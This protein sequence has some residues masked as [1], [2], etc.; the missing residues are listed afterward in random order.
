MAS[1]SEK[2]ALGKRI[3][4]ALYERGLIRT[5]YRDKPEGWTLV[6]GAWSPFYIQLRPVCSHPELLRDVSDALGRMIRDEAPHV[7]KIVGVAMAGI[8]LAVAASLSCRL[9]CLYT[10]KL[11]G[12]R[13]A[14]EL[15][16]AI[17]RY[18]EHAMVEGE[19]ADGDRLVVV[20]DLVTR[21]DSKLIAVRQVEHE[22]GRLR[23]QD[24]TCEDVAVVLDR[25]QGAAETARE[26][27]IRL[28]ALVPFATNALDWL[29]DVMA[30]L[31]RETI[32]DYLTQPD[33]YQS[34]EKQAELARAA[35]S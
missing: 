13:S 19:L 23:L 33:A 29:A 4:E 2:D 22:V 16:E 14:E 6:S 21:F 7:T 32:K 17:Q 3:V 26:H 12:V 27:G 8:P 34:P 5:W 9:P 35:A 1:S 18:G 15:A 24:V 28:H 31:E 10:R 20:D 25:E 30:P 11:E